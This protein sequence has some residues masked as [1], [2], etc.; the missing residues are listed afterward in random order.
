MCLSDRTYAVGR[1]L[2]AD[3]DAM[4]STRVSWG[5]SDHQGTLGR[6]DHGVASL[7]YDAAAVRPSHQG[8]AGAAG[9]GRGRGQPDAVRAD[10][11]V[12]DRVAAARCPAESDPDQS[13][14]A[15]AGA[16]CAQ[17]PAAHRPALDPRAPGW[18]LG[19]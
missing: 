9:A 18:Q 2:K 13:S 7:S 12:C 16:R 19:A 4:T 17:P 10:R 8:L 15:G 14:A 5:C 6:L 1:E 3:A 11:A